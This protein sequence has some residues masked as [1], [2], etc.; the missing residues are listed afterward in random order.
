MKKVLWRETE[1]H[2]FLAALEN[3]GAK[4]NWF[5]SIEVCVLEDWKNNKGPVM[6]G[7]EFSHTDVN[8]RT[9]MQE[10]VFKVQYTEMFETAMKAITEA[11]AADKGFNQP[12]ELGR[13][14][15]KTVIN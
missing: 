7:G 2:A 11:V 6:L 5:N 10:R 8:P 12:G 3:Q 4:I 15:D 1:L 13:L 14:L 9:M